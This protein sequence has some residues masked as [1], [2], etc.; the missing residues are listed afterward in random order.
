MSLGEVVK[1]SFRAEKSFTVPGCDRGLGAKA[2]A[3]EPRPSGIRF[4][5]SQTPS[6]I[7]GTPLS[8]LHDR[9]IHAPTPSGCVSPISDNPAESAPGATMQL[10][11]TIAIPCYNAER[12][13]RQAIQS[14]LDQQ[15]VEL[16][17]I[18]V[19]DG[20]TDGSVAIAREFGDRITLIEGKHHGANRCRNLALNLASGEWIQFLDADDY[21]EPGKIFTQVHEAIAPG[22]TVLRDAD[23]L[24]SPVWIETTTATG[25][26]REFSKTSPSADRFT[27]WIRWQIPQTGGALWRTQALRELGGWKQDQPC[28]QEHELYLRA[29]QAGLRF[30]FSPTPGAIYRV[31]SDDTLCRKDPLLVTRQRTALMDALLEWLGPM[32]NE[33][34]RREVGQA[35]FEMARTWARYD[36]EAALAYHNDRLAKGLMHV[37]GPAATLKYKIAYRIL[38]FARAERLAKAAR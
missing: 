15:G 17:I 24:Y 19:D 30:V 31:W 4:P 34:H 23:V 13:L 33:E 35:C 26:S 16:E 1:R 12:W 2:H 14:A 7:L 20:S 22:D 32:Q 27:Q 6:T 5:G 28:C 38:G 10:K 18:V 37:A 8:R 9:A 25:T 3:H 11:V 21:L 36:M 29:L